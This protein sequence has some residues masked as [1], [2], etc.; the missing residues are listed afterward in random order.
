[1]SEN[2]QDHARRKSLLLRSAKVVCSSGE[3]VCV[4][5]DVS[6]TGTTLRYLHAI[7]P[8][9]RLFLALAN[10]LTCPIELVDQEGDEATYRFASAISV[11]E[12]LH[13]S[14]PFDLRPIRLTIAASALVIDG[15]DTHSATLI[16]L[17]T[18]GAKFA[19]AGVMRP[20]RLI[21]FQISGTKQMLGQIAWCD[22]AYAPLH[23]GLQFRHP[24]GLRELAEAA[25]RIQPLGVPTNEEPRASIQATSA[26]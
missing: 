24:L 3:Y 22:R 25:L 23:Y 1:M 12:F 18:H 9:K 5:R 19:C 15:Q 11:D 14:Q 21:S 16:D 7:P 4:V 2:D 20:D 17:S 10:G 6:E 13:E 8:E 26:A